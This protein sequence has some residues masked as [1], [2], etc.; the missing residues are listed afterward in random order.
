MLEIDIR[1]ENQGV[2]Q[3]GL[4]L[5][6]VGDH[7]GGD[8]AAVEL[9]A[10]HDLAVGLGGLGLLHG[11]DAVVGDLLHGLGDELADDLVAGGDGATRAIS[12]LP[13][14]GLELP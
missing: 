4:H 2:V 13:L 9:H 8:V 1:I 14:T 7:I 5:L 6:G 10:L 3:N 12:S 11:D